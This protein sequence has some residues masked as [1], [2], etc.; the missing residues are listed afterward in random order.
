MEW[1]LGVNWMSGMEM[2]WDFFALQ[3]QLGSRGW[4]DLVIKKVEWNVYVAIHFRCPWFRDQIG[5]ETGR[6]ARSLFLT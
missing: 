4:Y 3:K 2:N 5:P 1:S 6:L